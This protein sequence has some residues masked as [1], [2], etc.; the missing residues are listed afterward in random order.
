[1]KLGREA[2]WAKA[3]DVAVAPAPKTS[4]GVSAVRDDGVFSK[5]AEAT[6]RKLQIKTGL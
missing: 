3:S 2:S 6:P 4:Y 1:M 5:A